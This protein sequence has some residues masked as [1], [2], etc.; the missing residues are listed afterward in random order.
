MVTIEFYPTNIVYRVANNKAV[1]NLYGRTRNDEKVCVADENFR[2]YF[3]VQ[4]KED[5]EAE[6]FVRKISAFETEKKGERAAI[7]GTEFVDKKLLGKRTSLLKVFANLPGMVP[8]LRESIKDM[9]EVKNVYEADIPFVR[10]YLIDRGIFPMTL[11]IAEGE[12]VNVRS[13]IPVLKAEK[14]KQVSEESLT[15]PRILAMDIETYNPTLKIEMEKNPII[16]VAFYSKGFRKVLTWKR[17]EKKEDYIE[18]VEDESA[19]L[20]RLKEIIDDFR[21]DI[22][23]GYF[24]DTFDWPY[25]KAR[26]D[27]YKIRMDLGADYSTIKTNLRTEATEITGIASLDVYKFIK[28]VVGRKLKTETYKLDEVA[29]EI[30]GEGK[31]N[32]VSVENMASDWN[33]GK[34]LEDYCRYNLQD[35]K[36]TYELTETLLPNMIEIVKIVGLPVSDI[37]DMGFSQLVEWYLLRRA[38]EFDEIAPNKPEHHEMGKRLGQT[39]EGAFVYEPT[40]G[41]YKNIIVFDFRS[42]YPSIIVSHNISP[43]TFKCSCCGQKL[44]PVEK[45]RY[46]FC[47]KKKGFIPKIV[48]ELIKRR[49]RVKEIMKKTSDEKTKKLLDARQESLKVLSNSFYGYLGFPAARWYSIESALS[50]T[51][52]ERNYIKGVIEK[53]EK[54]GFKVLYSDTDSVFLAL[55]NKTKED[56]LKFKDSV[57]LE[58]PELMELDYDGMFPSG[59]F[60]AVK[61]KGYGAKKKYALLSEEGFI[62]IKGFETVRRN[63]SAVAKETQKNVL[64]IILERNDPKKAIDYVKKVVDDL[65]SKKIPVEKTIMKTQ[66]QKQI[67]EYESIGPH[68]AVAKRMKESGAEVYPGMIIKW[69]VVSGKGKIGDR[70]K[71]FEELKKDESYDADYYIDNQVIPAVESILAVFGYSKW[72]IISDKK[73]SSLKGFMGK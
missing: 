62:K 8:A 44:A 9:P 26:A 12:F 69:V 68:V 23:T 52:Y 37:I 18:F 71:H 46:W 66:L 30:I 60:V 33:K 39:Y 70:S 35:A 15:E 67:G 41:L 27:K 64:K 24:S 58:L 2:P 29:K 1:I 5:V 54:A 22:I 61:A 59:L 10:R 40:P 57:N 11:T 38:P 55:N 4:I 63:W 19:L 14:I 3:Y 47:E 6:L 51:A 34:N 53:A 31:Y 36:I 73:Q 65:R 43:A 49:M 16:M 56:A 42:M 17:F 45:A 25:I 50:V 32:A 21:P 72:D 20:E 48:E 7:T 28:R 13:R